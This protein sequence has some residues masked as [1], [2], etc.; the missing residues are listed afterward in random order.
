[1]NSNEQLAYADASKNRIHIFFNGTLDYDRALRLQQAYRDAIAQCEPGFTVVTYAENYKPGDDKVQ[2]I[3]AEMTKMAEDAGLRKVARVVGTSPLGGMQI[4]R[5]AKMKTKY[6]SRHFA[7]K[8]E[9]VA[10]LDSHEDE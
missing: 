2:Q 5:L 1:M 8:E 7:T 3:V 9:A 4:N 6:P 10:Y